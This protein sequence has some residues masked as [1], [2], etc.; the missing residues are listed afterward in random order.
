MTPDNDTR[1]MTRNFM[2]L[3]KLCYLRHYLLPQEFVLYSDHEA[4]KY[5]NSQ[6]RLNARHSKWVE[7]LQDYTFVLKHKARVEN[8]VPDALS[9]R[10]M[11]L[12]T[13]SAEVSGFER[14]REEY[15]S[16]PDF[17]KIY[18]TLWDSSVREMDGFLLQDGYLFK[19]RKLCIPRTSLRNFLS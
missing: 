12:I 9:Q 13:M 17:E 3:N 18:V 2:R 10:V 5:L 4:L 16:C 6:K 14:L 11:I 8:K 19:L 15:D 1:H 7:F